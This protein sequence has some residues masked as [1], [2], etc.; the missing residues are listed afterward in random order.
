MNFEKISVTIYDILGY[1]LPGFVVL[2][3]I[4]LIEATFLRS[5]VLYLERLA[6]NPVIATVIAYFLGQ[7]SHAIASWLKVKRRVWF[8]DEK[9]RLSK[10]VLART[11]EEL[12][13]FYGINLTDGCFLNTLEMYQLAEGYVAVSG[14]F[15]DR[16]VYLAREGFAKAGMVAMFFLFGTLVSCAVSGGAVVRLSSSPSDMVELSWIGTASCA[17]LVIWMAL[18]FRRQFLFFSR[19]KNNYTLLAFLAYR[20]KEATAKEKR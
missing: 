15:S 11:E 2:F 20:L 3:A 4:S 19:L 1:I 14:G 16:A 6:H 7:V 17:L 8:T 18:I 12:R 13:A 5:H 9:N 10:P